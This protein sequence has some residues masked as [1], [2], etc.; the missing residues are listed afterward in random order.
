MK[1]LF[2]IIFFV[3]RSV[4]FEGSKRATTAFESAETGQFFKLT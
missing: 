3:Q 4:A 1:T 2:G